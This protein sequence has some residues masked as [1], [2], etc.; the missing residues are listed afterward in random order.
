MDAA[1]ASLASSA[2]ASAAMSCCFA[3]VIAIACYARRDGR[4]TSYCRD[5]RVAAE[6]AELVAP[7]GLAH[8]AQGEGESEG[9]LR[10]EPSSYHRVASLTAAL[11]CPSFTP[12]LG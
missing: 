2:S 11:A 8:L 9:G 12:R 6:R 3:A 1:A 10:R 7:L 5:G 4:V